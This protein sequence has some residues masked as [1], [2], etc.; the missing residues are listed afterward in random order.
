[1]FFVVCVALTSAPVC[2]TC[3]HV[4]MATPVCFSLNISIKV[5][6]HII[7]LLYTYAYDYVSQTNINAVQ[8]KKTKATD[9]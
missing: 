5:Q 9:S 4:L 7:C 1:M 3:Q 8:F 6:P 2:E